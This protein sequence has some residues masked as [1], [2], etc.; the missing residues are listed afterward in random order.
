MNQTN[1]ISRAWVRAVVLVGGI[2]YTF[3]GLALLFAPTWFFNTIG[4][5]PPF[6]RHYMGDLGSFIL[7][8]GIGLIIASRNPARH[9]GLIGA[10]VAANLFHA[11]NHV[12]DAIIGNQPMSRWMLDSVPLLVFAIIF[13][14]A[15]RSQFRAT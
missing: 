4:T 9:W 13:G 8:M 2:F 1:K 10:V 14:I 11:I 15:Y 12:Y 3:I 6:N 7:P 5:F